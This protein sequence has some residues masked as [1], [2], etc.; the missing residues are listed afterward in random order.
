MNLSIPLFTYPFLI[1]VLGKDKYGLV[2]YAQ[3][4]VAYLVI[5]VSFGFNITAVRDIS[6]HREN[7]EKVNEIFSSIIIIK[8]SLFFISF[9]ILGF[10]LNYVPLAKGYE[11]LFLL[12]MQAC[13]SDIIFPIWYFQGIEQMKY[14]TYITLVSRIFFLGLVFIF[15]KAPTDYLL[16]PLFNGISTVITGVI[17]MFIIFG[18]HKVKISF[19]SYRI[20]KL[21]FLESISVFISEVSIVLYVNTNKVIVGSFLG[22]VNLSYYDLA[23]KITSL[24]KI[25]QSILTQTIFPKI[26]RDRNIE[27]VK[28]IFKYSII[29]YLIIVFLIHQFSEQIVVIIGGNQMKDAAYIVNILTLSIPFIVVSNIFGILTLLPFGYKKEY[30]KVII[31]SGLFYLMLIII[32]NVTIGFSINSI[33]SVTL[34]TEIF[35]SIY[36]FYYLKKYTLWTKSMIT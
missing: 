24:L 15:I 11:F 32:L 31:S 30:T 17:S 33:A 22:L 6:V 7:K 29:F 35:V 4:I 19:Q 10:L 2:L 3:A 28:N 23:E 20:I 14:I 9:L 34:L 26:N 36:M 25:P 12:S 1:R 18:T 13:L 5:L 27:M 21:Y 8:I 16:I